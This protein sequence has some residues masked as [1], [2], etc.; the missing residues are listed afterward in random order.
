MNNVQCFICA[1][2]EPYCTCPKTTFETKL[3]PVPKPTLWEAVQMGSTSA[4][5]QLEREYAKRL[6]PLIKEIEEERNKYKEALEIISDDKI[7]D[8]HSL[9]LLSRSITIAKKALRTT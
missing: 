8:K 9:D 5:H 4:G 3:I 7:L 1:K 6:W 2:F